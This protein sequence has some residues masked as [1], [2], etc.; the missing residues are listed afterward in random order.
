MWTEL[1]GYWKNLKRSWFGND[2]IWVELERI[3]CE[4]NCNGFGDMEKKAEYE[5]NWKRLER[6]ENELKNIMGA[7]LDWL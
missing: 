2:S 3:R 5:L 1:E 4:L 6:F 7:E